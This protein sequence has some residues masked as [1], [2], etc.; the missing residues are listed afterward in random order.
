M[1]YGQGATG[2]THTLNGLLR[3]SVEELYCYLRTAAGRQLSASVSVLELHHESVRDLVSGKSNL[4]IQMTPSGVSFD[5]LAEMPCSSAKTMM[6]IISQAR[7][8]ASCH[9]GRAASAGGGRSHVVVQIKVQPQPPQSA[10][11]SH[12]L[13]IPPPSLLTF[14]DLAKSEQ[15]PTRTLDIIAGGELCIV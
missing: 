11:A 12:P 4:P 6:D 5:G 8:G 14:F 3:R 10:R 15:V 9:T 2:K 13:A 1:T 7:G